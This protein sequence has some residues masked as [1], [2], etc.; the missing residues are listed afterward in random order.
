MQKEEIAPP[1]EH[2]ADHLRDLEN[3]QLAELAKDYRWLD[4]E[5]R[6]AE[7]RAE[8][9]TRRE[10]IIRECERRRHGRPL[11]GLPPRS[12]SCALRR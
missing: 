10:A 7:S 1:P 4:E 2:W 9:H 5:A 8:F 11:P 12:L 3:N 6:P